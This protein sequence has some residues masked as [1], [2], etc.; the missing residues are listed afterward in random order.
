M[1]YIIHAFTWFCLGFTF[2][3]ILDMII[4]AWEFKKEMK[5][6]KKEMEKK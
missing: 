4:S 6:L 5:Q 2:A 1:S 3:Q